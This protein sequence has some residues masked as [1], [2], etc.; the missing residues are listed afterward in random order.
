MAFGFGLGGFWENIFSG[1][2]WLTLS[3]MYLCVS[4]VM[5]WSAEQQAGEDSSWSLSQ[6]DQPQRDVPA[7][8]P[9]EQ[10]RHGQ[11]HLQVNTRTHSHTRMD[12]L[13]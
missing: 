1:P 4:V 13:E 3:K 8:Q 12:A 7:G 10:R 6:S 9:A 5:M 11:P 2:I